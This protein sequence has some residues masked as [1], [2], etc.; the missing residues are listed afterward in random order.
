MRRKHVLCN[1]ASVVR[2][3]SHSYDFVEQNHKS[4]CFMLTILS[5]E[6]MSVR[7]CQSL[8]MRIIIFSQRLTPVFVCSLVMLYFFKV[9]NSPFFKFGWTER[10]NPWRRIESGLWTNIH[11][12][13]L[14]GKLSHE[15]LD[16]IFLFEGDRKVECYAEYR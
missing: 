13:E 11:P 3:Y 10:K 1:S 8:H 14:C 4:M 12:N 5:R 16:L 7:P 15:N 6:S 2:H 9:L